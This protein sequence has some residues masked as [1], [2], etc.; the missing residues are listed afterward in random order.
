MEIVTGG[1]ASGKTHLLVQWVKAGAPDGVR[2]KIVCMTHQEAN[3]LMQDHNLRREQVCTFRDVI[4][5]G[6]AMRDIEY[7][8][9][10][11]DLMLQGIVGSGSVKYATFATPPNMNALARSEATQ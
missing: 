7:A 9:D 4:T 5:L 11:L 10:N 8:F 6:A 1:R 3:R 2:R